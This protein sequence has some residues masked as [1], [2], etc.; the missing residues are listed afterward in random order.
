ML[1]DGQMG[2]VSALLLLFTKLMQR[3][4]KILINSKSQNTFIITMRVFVW[5]IERVKYRKQIIFTEL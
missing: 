3:K 1:P 5:R 4:R 2:T